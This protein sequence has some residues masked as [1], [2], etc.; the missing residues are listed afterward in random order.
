[1]RIFNSR[2][3]S[4][5]TTL[6]RPH[7]LGVDVATAVDSR[8]VLTFF[9]MS[10]F[11]NLNKFQKSEITFEVGGRVQV[12]LEKYLYRG[13][14][15]VSSIHC[16]GIFRLPIVRHPLRQFSHLSC[17]L[18]RFQLFLCLTF[19]QQSFSSF[20]LTLY[21]A[22]FI[23]V[24]TVFPTKQAFIPLP[25][26]RSFILVLSLS[27]SL[28]LFT[29]SILLSSYCRILVAYTDAVLPKLPS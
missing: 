26:L 6:P 4:Y 3:L 21:P 25:S 24:F 13:V 23:H 17:S 28:S 2:T 22:H 19:H 5:I 10:G 20:I 18:P 11:A 12:S 14:C 7:H 29:P 8:S 16:F 15:V 9:T 1:M 27:L